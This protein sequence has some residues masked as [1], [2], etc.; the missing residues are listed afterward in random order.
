MTPDTSLHYLNLYRRQHLA[1]LK[2]KPYSEYLKTKE[3]QQTRRRA[4]KSAGYKCQLCG[5]DNVELHVHHKTYDNIGEEKPDDL[6]VLCKA[7]HEK[8]HGKE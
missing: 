5:T 4:L 7:C 1:E 2:A 3:W 6:I 8:Q